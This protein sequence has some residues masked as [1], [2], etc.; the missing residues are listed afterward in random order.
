MAIS[1]SFAVFLFGVIHF[2]AWG[3]EFRTQTE[4]DLWR[5]STVLTITVVPAM[6]TVPF[7][8]RQFNAIF[9]SNPPS[10]WVSMARVQWFKVCISLWILGPLFI[11]ARLFILVE[12]IRSLAYQPPGSY[13]TTWAAYVPHMG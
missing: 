2:A 12:V 3:Y 10:R 4:R 8:A 7:L 5:A 9:N 13:K 11:A 6:V 1:S